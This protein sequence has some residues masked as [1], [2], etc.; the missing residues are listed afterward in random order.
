MKISNSTGNTGNQREKDV[1]TIIFVN[2][3]LFVFTVLALAGYVAVIYIFFP[4]L[5]FLYI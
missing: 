3:P 5:E 2:Q 4:H 1:K